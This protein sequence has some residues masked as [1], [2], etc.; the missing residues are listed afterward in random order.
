MDNDLGDLQHVFWDAIGEEFGP[1][2]RNEIAN[3]IWA[4]SRIFNPLP[5]QRGP[6]ARS[7]LFK[8]ME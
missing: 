8:E 6:W 1:A 4:G 5:N 3:M 2:F 7:R